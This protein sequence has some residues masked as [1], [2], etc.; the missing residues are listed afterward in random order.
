M[1]TY[2]LIVG[3]FNSSQEQK[4]MNSGPMFYF[5]KKT[6]YFPENLITCQW[7]ITILKCRRY[8]LKCLVFHWHVSFLGGR[9]QKNTQTRN[10]S[11]IW[12]PCDR[13]STS[14]PLSLVQWSLLL[15]QRLGCCC[16]N[17]SNDQWSLTLPENGWLK[18]RSGFLLGGQFFLAY[19]Q[20]QTCGWF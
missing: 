12:W 9:P 1:F 8:I 13:P 14:C 10:P 5:A 18:R 20:G 15:S 3:G 19:F 4:S 2:L 11:R 7:K 6:I 16:G 17:M